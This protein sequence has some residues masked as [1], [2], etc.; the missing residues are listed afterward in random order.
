MRLLI[1]VGCFTLLHLP[2][3]SIERCNTEVDLYSSI[4]AVRTRTLAVVYEDNNY[5]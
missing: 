1:L 4:G 5:V 2:D 3:H